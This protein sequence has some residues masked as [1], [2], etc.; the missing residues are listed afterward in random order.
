VG[1]SILVAA[2]NIL[3]RAR[4]YSDLSA[5][6]SVSTAAIHRDTS[7]GSSDS[8]EPSADVTLQPV[9]AE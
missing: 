6:Y 8:F 1:H 5:D 9:E 4:P 2:P 3:D 7:T